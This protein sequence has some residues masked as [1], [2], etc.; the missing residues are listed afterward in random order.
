MFHWLS[1]GLSCEALN[2]PNS[3][4]MKLSTRMSAAAM[5]CPDSSAHRCLPSLDIASGNAYC[6][7]KATNESLAGTAWS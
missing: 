7:L 4:P 5:A 6:A 3:L 2:E 1:R